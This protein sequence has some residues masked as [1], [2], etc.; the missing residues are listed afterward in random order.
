[1]QTVHERTEK[2]KQITSIADD[3]CV[4]STSFYSHP[5]TFFNCP[6]KEPCIHIDELDR[7]DAQKSTFAHLQCCVNRAEW[8][9]FVELRN[10][11]S[12]SFFLLL[13]GFS[14]FIRSDEGEKAKVGKK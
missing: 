11:V 10:S 3:W 8:D 13:F 2:K 6:Q 7:Y 12:G 4:R 14:L 5:A 1:M 9:I